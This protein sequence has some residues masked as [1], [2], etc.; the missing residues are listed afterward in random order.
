ML[1]LAQQVGKPLYHS[2]ENMKRHLFTILILL[3]M[4]VMPIEVAA[5]PM[6]SGTAT[7]VSVEYVPGKGP[8]FIFTVSGKFSRSNLKGSLHVEGGR[9]TVSTVHKWMKSQSNVIPLKKSQ[10]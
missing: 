4:L 3:S 1:L 2:E 10:V 8:V 7:L 6:A 9:I 5:A